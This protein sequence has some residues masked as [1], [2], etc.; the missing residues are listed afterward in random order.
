MVKLK[1]YR[2][3]HGIKITGY[4]AL[5]FNQLQKFI[6]DHS[7][8]ERNV[9]YDGSVNYDLKK[10]YY[11]L[12]EDTKTLYIHRNTWDTFLGYCANRGISSNDIEVTD[13]PVPE[14]HDAQYKLFDKYVLRDYQV[15]IDE[16]IRKGWGRGVPKILPEHR[17]SRVDL[18]TG[19]GKGLLKTAKVKIPN[20]WTTIGEL[21]VGDTITGWDGKPTKVTGVY[22]QPKQTVYRLNFAD[23][24]TIVTDGPH[25]WK[26]YT[27]NAYKEN[28]WT[29]QN[30]EELFRLKQL[31]GTRVYIPLTKHDEDKDIEL[32]IPPYTLGVILGD[33]CI[34]NGIE[35]SKL[36]HEIFEHVEKELPNELNLIVKN[37]LTRRISGNGRVGSNTYTNYLRDLGLFGKLSYDKFVPDIYLRGSAKQRLALL[38]GLLDTDGTTGKHGQVSFSSSSYKLATDVQYL[39]RSLGGIA[40][41]RHKTP[42]YTHNGIKKSGRTAYIVGIRYPKPAELFRLSRKRERVDYVNQ[43]SEN[44]KLRLESVTI[45][46]VNETVCISVDHP[47]KLF[48]T[49]DFIVTHNTLSSLATVANMGCKAVIMVSP[50][51]FGIWIKALT[52]TYENIEGR[53][54]TVGGGDELRSLIDRAIEKDLGNIDFFIVSNITYRTFLDNYETYGDDIEQAGFNCTPYQFHEV[55]G[56]GVQINDEYQDDPGLAFRIDIFTNVA[57]QI[58]LSA[59]PFTGDK[60][61]TKMIDVA[62]PESTKVRLPEYKAYINGLELIYYDV[63]VKPKD[64]LTPFKNTYNHT[65]YETMMLKD[66]KRFNQYLL[67]VERI[68]EGLFL[69]D[70]VKGQKCLLLFAR[71]IFI[72][73]VLKHLKKKYPKVR[74]GRHVSGSKYEDLLKNDITL[75]TI[76]SSGTGVDIINLRECVMFHATDSEKD[77]IQILGRCRPLKDFPG[78]TPRFTWLTCANIPHHV[79]YGTN[80]KKHFNGRILELKRMRI[81]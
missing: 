35:I 15:A 65:R 63:N 44:L 22:P 32:P 41:I 60:Y 1:A 76:K 7:L 17:S 26:V 29:I 24:R 73:T 30:T 10:R 4:D 67:M 51:Y 49:D 53:Y 8:I 33:G 70:Y 59:T 47:D 55:L 11:G 64:F 14:Y 71:I 2:Y 5:T 68:V 58:F 28:K 74:I 25:L 38:Q 40:R 75:S 79:R 54:M 36:D 42:T 19:G 3:S 34:R 72:D 9:S 77:N 31:K 21:K 66:K 12:S 16:D 52:E 27:T 45:E 13:A 43:Y 23:G 46:G 48:I 18:Y 57:K 61:V 78:V 50:K 20:G 39:V 56:V 62:L 6:T 81:A 69:K 37:E 80:K